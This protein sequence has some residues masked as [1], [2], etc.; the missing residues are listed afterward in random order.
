M[1]APPKTVLS[2]RDLKDPDA[3]HQGQ[4]VHTNIAKHE[5]FQ[6]TWSPY[7]VQLD[8]F[9][10]SIANLRD[11]MMAAATKDLIKVAFCVTCRQKLDHDY[12]YVGRYAE[13]VV[14]PDY[15]IMEA[16]GYSLAHPTSHKG[17]LPMQAPANPTLKH[18]DKEGIII[19]QVDALPGVKTIEAQY[20]TGDPT[21][22]SNFGLSC[23]FGD[24]RDM[25]FHNLVPGLVYSFR[26]RG[27]FAKGSGPWSV[28]VT[29]RAI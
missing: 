3:L 11:A 24:R 8:E 5:L 12:Y 23:V 20:T 7:A 28:I 6:H 29:L 27:I 13:L 16:L 2:L 17:P 14:R 15:S 22:E 21:V 4:L 18:G 19:A 10:A 25:Q 26:F 9:G 1:F